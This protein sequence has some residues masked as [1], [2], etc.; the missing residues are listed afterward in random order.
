M[1]IDKAPASWPSRRLAA[2]AAAT[3]RSLAASSRASSS[4]LPASE[5][6]SMRWRGDGGTYRVAQPP[7][8]SL[9]AASQQLFIRGLMRML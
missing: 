1:L 3:S 6:A 2:A 8:C 9:A 7:A 4:A 5:P